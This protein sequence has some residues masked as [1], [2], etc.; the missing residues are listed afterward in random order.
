VLATRHMPPWRVLMWVKFTEVVLQARPKALR[1][2]YLNPDPELRHAM[3]W[4]T[5]MGR[6]VW[7]Y[8]IFRFF[9]ERR[10]KGGPTVAEYWG[11]PQDGEEES[12]TVAAKPTRKAA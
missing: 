10:V 11:A 2:T 5:Q 6:R 3:A 12:M 4:Y 9:L 1:R 7:P 8:E